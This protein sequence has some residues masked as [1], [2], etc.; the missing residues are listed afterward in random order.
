MKHI[1]EIAVGGFIVDNEYHKTIGE[2]IAQRD[3]AILSLVG[4]KA[5]ISGVTVDA[6]NHTNGI[7]TYNGKIYSFVGGVTQATVTTKRVAIDRPNESQVD[8]PAYYEDIIAFGDDG[9]ETFPFSDL[10]RFYINAPELKEI[11]IIGRNITNAEL[12]G[13][14]W[15]VADGTNTTDN[16][17]DKFFVVA[18]GDHAVGNTVGS[19]TKVIA[20]ANLPKVSSG[21]FGGEVGTGWPDSAASN[22]AQGDNHS[23]PRKTK[24]IKLD[25]F[26]A[27]N[28]PLDI[29]PLSYAVVAIQFIG[30]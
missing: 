13:T 4:N 26:G 6:A 28:T 8:A 11:K 12:A 27:N 19:K 9:L 14:G 22:I 7:I 23:Y 18:G 2:M 15:F 1:A 3:V 16:L 21:L 30:I 25:D 29:T 24:E 17:I 10:N 20:A 5:I